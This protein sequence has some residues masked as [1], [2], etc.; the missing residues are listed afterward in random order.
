LNEYAT[1]QSDKNEGGTMRRRIK[2][3]LSLFS[4]VVL[5]G[6]IAVMFSAGS[7]IAKSIDATQTSS[8]TVPKECSETSLTKEKFL[9]MV[10][11][12]ATHGDLSDVQFIEKTLGVKLERKIYPGQEN[13]RERL[14]YSNLP[15][16]KARAQLK[17]NPQYRNEG[18]E[19]NPKWVS[20]GTLEFQDFADNG[21][22]SPGCSPLTKDVIEQEIVGKDFLGAELTGGW[23][24]TGGGRFYGRDLGS[25][26]KNGTAIRV[27]Y[28]PDV[29]SHKINAF[30][31]YQTASVAIHLKP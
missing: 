4:K 17:F 25:I 2:S 21:I 31:I 5:A 9:Q 3:R 29:N 19:K 28:I 15:D 24:L 14:Y 16:S 13:V 26:G 22:V 23:G 7:V 18:S 6:S 27:E 12:I 10:R 20:T 8:A 30:V 11:T 1:A